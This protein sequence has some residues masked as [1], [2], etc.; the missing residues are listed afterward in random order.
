MQHSTVLGISI[1]AVLALSACGKHEPST[2][3]KS[4]SSGKAIVKIGHV[5]PLTGSIA[6]LG[7]DN[8]NGV[9]LAIEDANAKGV[10]I[11]GK[12]ITFQLVT[13]DDQA[14]PKI[15]T[16]V[17]QKL[18]DAKVAGV[19]GHLNS[20]TT[21]PASKIYAD[22]GIPQISGSATTPK[23]TQQG[24]KTA[25][26]LMANDIQQGLVLSNFITS[27]LNAKQVAIIDDRSAYG[28][29]LADEVEK[30]VKSNGAKIVA[31]EYT[32][33]K[34]TDFKSILTAIKAQNP[35]VVFYGG[36]DA[37]GGPMLKQ[38]RELG[39]KAQF[40]QGDGGCT[41]QF[42]K[43]AGNAAEGFKC[44]QAGM[45]V[46]MMPN[47]EDFQSRFEKK[48]GHIQ[49]YAPYTYDATSVLIAA[50][51]KAKSTDPAKYLP[52]LAKI[53]YDGVTGKVEFDD[54]GDLRAGYITLYE[55]K[56]GKLAVLSMHNA[57]TILKTT[58]IK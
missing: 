50:M 33:E 19:I 30:N 52:E 58:E 22:A 1:I 47:A 29:G 48:F 12:K 53:S 46:V 44:S 35:E 13:E 43:L 16:I 27:E 2:E 20:G 45:P 5:A 37:T 3:T 36:M 18:V 54:K 57:S 41:H 24:F 51:Q 4:S 7:K 34:A 11:G 40:L 26:R 8:E 56:L 21:I 6:H 39:I 10:E 55:V 38:M 14:D 49:L 23:Y 15:S 25:F 31:R 42:I 17:A 9:R 28:Q 32:N